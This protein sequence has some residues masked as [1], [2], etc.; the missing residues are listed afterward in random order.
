MKREF[1]KN[2][3][4]TDE[5][6]SE[7]MTEHGKTVEKAKTDTSKVNQ[8]L[9]KYKEEAEGLKTQL[10]DANAQIQS[11]K[12][13][14]IEGIKKS[15]NDW[16]AKYEADTQKLNKQLADK[17][18]EYNL[19]DFTGKYKFANDRVQNSIIA[20]LKAKEFKLE[21]GVFLGAD[22][23]MK[24]LQESEPGSFITDEPKEPQPQIVKPTRGSKPPTGVVFG[25][26]FTGVRPVKATINN[27]K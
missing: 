5:Q 26:S 25:M 20:D 21:N 23:Y 27:L 6:V 22:D 15:A 4:L 16:K 24:Q 19:K 8:E 17:E 14:D 13:M 12:D 9:E 10:I 3:G 18:Y 1:L 11:F 7:I 2:L